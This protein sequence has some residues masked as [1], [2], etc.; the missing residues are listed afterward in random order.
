M[1]TSIWLVLLLAAWGLGSTPP[2]RA[3][4]T[5]IVYDASN[6]MWGQ[7]DGE[8][9]ISIARRVMGDLVRGWDDGTRVGLVAYGHRRAGDCSDIETVAPLG[10]LDREALRQHRRA[11]L[12]RPRC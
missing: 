6:S 9:K 8:P 4:D 3:A 2:A 11:I 12:R 1:R 5:V 7:I 10:E